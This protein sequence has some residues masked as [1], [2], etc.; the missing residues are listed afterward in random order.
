MRRIIV[1]LPHPLGPIT[2]TN[3]PATLE[4]QPIDRRHLPNRFGDPDSRTSDSITRI[5]A[6]FDVR[7]ADVAFTRFDRPR[8]RRDLLMVRMSGAC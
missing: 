1:V 2:E 8:L 6:S 7:G 4:T 3:S 5:D